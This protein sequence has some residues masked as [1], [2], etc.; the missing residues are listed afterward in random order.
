M[1]SLT[2]IEA[3]LNTLFT[4][5]RPK[6]H[7]SF[8]WLLCRQCL[9]ATLS[10]FVYID[11][12]FSRWRYDSDCGRQSFFPLVRIHH[13]AGSG[14]LR[15]GVFGVQSLL[16]S[17]L[18]IGTMWSRISFFEKRPW[19]YFWWRNTTDALYVRCRASHLIYVLSRTLTQ[20]GDRFRY[21]EASQFIGSFTISHDLYKSTT[22][23]INPKNILTICSHVFV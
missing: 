13:R 8:R 10:Y 17:F 20:A 19:R 3:L 1:L 9:L 14:D 11:I 12:L 16:L 2:I 21:I 6:T 22:K 23:K 15:R 4:L 18:G 5:P 7:F